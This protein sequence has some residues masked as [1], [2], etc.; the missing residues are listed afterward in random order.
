MRYLQRF[1]VLAVMLAATGVAQAQI[2]K[3][4]LRD[5]PEM[6]KTF[7]PVIAKSSEATVRVFAHGKAVAYGTIVDADGLILTKWD[8]VR[9]SIKIVCRLRDGKEL[10]AKIVGVEKDYDLAMLKVEA[11]ELPTVQ[12]EDAKNATVGRWVAS[13]GTGEDPLAVGVISVA[14]RKLVLGDQ[15]P[16]N[17]NVNSGRPQSQ[18]CHLRSRRPQGH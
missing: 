9:G 6:L 3:E 13:A 1:F 4:D 5:S 12:W 17:S 18:R 7:R 15:P 8:E 2:R 16:K 10:E 11:S 14:R